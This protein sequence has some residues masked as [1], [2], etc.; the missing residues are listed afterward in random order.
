MPITPGTR[1]GPYEVTALLGTGGM[2]EVYRARDGK[3]NRDVAI[4][5]LS[6]SFARRP[7]WLARH[8]RAAQLLASLNHPYIAHI[9]SLEEFA[10]AI[11]DPVHLRALV[12]ERV[13]GETLAQ[14]IGR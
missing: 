4:K 1:L 10:A 12:I 3:L 5:I 6:D 13:E 11:P 7:E 9:Y 8:E 2:S 14:R